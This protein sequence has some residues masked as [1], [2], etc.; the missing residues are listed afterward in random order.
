MSV[1]AVTGAG[2]YIGRRLLAHL[3]RNDYCSRVLATDLNDPGVYPDKVVF[4][5]KDIR[6]SGLYDFFS[7]YS[8]DCLVHLAFI[9]D[10]MHNEDEMYD[11]NVNGTLN[12]LDIC[13]KLGVKHVIAASSASAYGAY[14]DNPEL[15][16]E[17]DPIRVFP[18]SFSYPHQKGIN[19]KH[20]RDFMD[21]NP[22]VLFNI[23][24]PCIVYGPN[25]NNYISRFWT[26][27]PVI[28]LLNGNDTPWQFV[29]ED[30]AAAFII[31]LLEARIPGSFNLAP[32]DTVKYSEIAAMLGKPVVRV[33]L[34]PARAL[35]GLLWRLRYLEMPSGALDFT[36]FSWVVDSSKGMRQLGFRYRYGSR[37]T[38]EIGLR[39]R[40]LWAKKG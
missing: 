21:R 26:K 35:A 22:D 3:A 6:D 5:R 4:C 38:V 12:I 33:P 18:R 34:G 7:G 19:E 27:F 13:R 32:P 24:R 17:D 9:V 16:T 31:R 29:H 2:G 1:I 20:F 15:L 23:V 25:V 8:V 39:A 14:P 40:G 30:D 10:P 36:A 28:M 11:I 37:E